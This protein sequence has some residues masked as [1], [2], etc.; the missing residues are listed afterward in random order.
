MR[1]TQVSVSYAAYK[2][3]V[4]IAEEYL[5]RNIDLQLQHL[6]QHV[7][8]AA[9]MRADARF[10]IKIVMDSLIL[11]ENIEPLNEVHFNFAESPLQSWFH[12]HAD[13]ISAI[14]A[15]MA[16][17]VE[18]EFFVMAL[19]ISKELR[20]MLDEED[21]QTDDVKLHVENVL[22]PISEAF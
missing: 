16:T 13:V 1:P 7:Q 9:H 3:G 11:D 10:I 6:G 20:Y 4:G 17:D 19:N 15:R 8:W 2:K 21:E 14:G 5:A 22:T 12:S 18:R